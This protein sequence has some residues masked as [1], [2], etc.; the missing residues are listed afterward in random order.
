MASTSSVN[1][2][3]TLEIN[4]RGG[5]VGS[6]DDAFVEGIVDQRKEKWN[7]VEG[8]S[9]KKRVN[10]SPKGNEPKKSISTVSDGHSE[11]LEI[12]G[13]NGNIMDLNQVKLITFLMDNNVARENIKPHKNYVTVKS[14]NRE[15]T[16]QIINTKRILDL[17]VST[18]I[19]FFKP[20]QSIS[21]LGG[22]E[23][24][25]IIIFNVPNSFSD[26][27]IKEESNCDF[28]KKIKS[29]ES[30]KDHVILG[31]VDEAP[32]HV[33]IGFLSFRTKPY[34]PRP[35]RCY[36]CNKFGH[37]AQNCRG[38][39]TCP[40]CGDPHSFSDCTKDEQKCSNCGGNH[41]ASASSCPVFIKNQEIINIKCSNK[42]SYAKAVEI[43]STKPVTKS[44]HIVATTSS[45]VNMQIM[46][47]IV[48]GES[49]GL[50]G[51]NPNLVSLQCNS[52]D[53]LQSNGHYW[54]SNGS[55]G[56]TFTSILQDLLKVLTEIVNIILT[57]VQTE[58]INL[59]LQKL[60][61]ILNNK[62]TNNGS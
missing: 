26:E 21:S 40:K 15:L 14:T 27:D 17:D 44:N 12:K 2:L 10:D 58:D 59:Q 56:L 32:L 42:V 6:M 53:Q 61:G 41:S 5:S 18:S 57:N 49:S 60:I 54:P 31:Y 22:Q 47:P 29:K 28:F 30:D 48:P 7:L 38:S 43:Y 24:N 39:V 45:E 3:D 33:R 4:S 13:V 20:K 1:K 62:I 34:I 8:K 19:K 50:S 46:E 52:G 11:I 51:T 55:Q 37:V 9:R 36:K 23:L 16:Q 35:T 25:K